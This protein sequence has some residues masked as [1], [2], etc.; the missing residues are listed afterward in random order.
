MLPSLLTTTK[1]PGNRGSES[2][3]DHYKLLDQLWLLPQQRGKIT[4]NYVLVTAGSESCSLK[5][6]ATGSDRECM[7]SHSPLF[8]LRILSESLRISVVH[9]AYRKGLMAWAGLERWLRG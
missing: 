2:D 3:E 7:N 4:P 6:S 1:H 5:N 9:C 8:F